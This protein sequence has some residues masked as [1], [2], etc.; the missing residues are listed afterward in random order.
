LLFERGDLWS[1]VIGGRNAA[2]F[3]KKTCDSPLGPIVVDSEAWQGAHPP[4]DGPT[5]ARLAF[6]LY[7][8]VALEFLAG[9]STTSESYSVCNGTLMIG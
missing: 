8:P 7:E 6:P 9:I 1:G 3:E 4:F 2:E 5:I